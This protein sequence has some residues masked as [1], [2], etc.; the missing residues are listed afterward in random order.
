MKNLA[1]K[2]YFLPLLIFAF[3]ITTTVVISEKLFLNKS[4]TE[5]INLAQLFATPLWQFDNEAIR[6][7]LLLAIENDDYSKISILDTDR[8]LI[9]QTT[10]SQERVGSYINKFLY[11]I[12]LV[13]QK[14]TFKGEDLGIIAIH[15]IN[16]NNTVYAFLAIILIGLYFFKSIYVNLKKNKLDMELLFKQSFNHNASLMGILDDETKSFIDIN[17]AFLHAFKFSNRKDVIGKNPDELNIFKKQDTGPSL[18]DKLVNTD[19]VHQEE[20]TCITRNNKEIIL[21]I[22]VRKVQLAQKTLLLFTSIDITKKKRSEARLAETNKKLIDSARVAGQAEIATGV[23]HNVG[24]ILNSA[25]I[26]ASV[27]RESICQ[28]PTKELNKTSELFRSTHTSEQDKKIGQYIDGLADHLEK[29]QHSAKQEVDNLIDH[30]HHITEVVQLHQSYSKSSHMIES[31]D[32]DS[33]IDDAIKVNQAGLERHGVT[34]IHHKSPNQSML[35]DRHRILQILI[36]FISN[37]KYATTDKKS[38]DKVIEISSTIKDEK[39]SISVKDNGMGMKEETRDKIFT[40]GFTTRTNGHGFGLHSCANVAGELDG[41]VRADS[42]GPGKGS[43]FTLTIP[44]NPVEK[45]ST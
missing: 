1:F 4:K 44:S 27:A 16:S 20:N 15:R 40:Y 30:L 43:T 31:V 18:L 23:L 5:A 26:S 7:Y 17:K 12:K 24:N 32:L 13:E 28:A 3:L 33:I 19:Q 37:A 6:Y 14:I 8:N 41:S 2:K 45:I 34:I 22:S 25:C 39:L 42:D 35:L 38:D 10:Q 21:L 9:E 36:N 11:N 29:Q